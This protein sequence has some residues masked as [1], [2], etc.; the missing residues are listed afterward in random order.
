MDSKDFELR[1][2]ELEIDIS[3][4]NEKTVIEKKRLELK[5]EQLFIDEYN[6]YIRQRKNWSSI[7]AGAIISLIIFN[8]FLIIGVGW[9]SLK[10][11]D[12]ILISVYWSFVAE[13][14]G[15]A[16]IVVR[17]LFKEKPKLLDPK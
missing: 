12:N 7:L 4:K 8:N 6:D 11:S 3:Q 14:L 5:R 16:A 9:G 10:I 2:T 17:Y 15:L 13:I 1:N